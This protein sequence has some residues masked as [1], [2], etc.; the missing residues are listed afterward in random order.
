ME[1]RELY[2]QKF[3]AQIREW[4]AKLDALEAH[5]D[6]VSAEAKIA[7][8]PHLDTVHAQADSGE[9]A[10]PRSAPEI[11]ISPSSSGAF[12]RTSIHLVAPCLVVAAT[13]AGA[14]EAQAGP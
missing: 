6:R 13:L 3:E 10:P 5:A 7:A 9:G 11:T 4:N 1:P 12:M 8:K 14:R 2:K